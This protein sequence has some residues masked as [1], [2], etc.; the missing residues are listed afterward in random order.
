[1]IEL[2]SILND[3]EYKY[4]MFLDSVIEYSDPEAKVEIRKRPEGFLITIL[5]SNELFKDR[6]IK[7]NLDYNSQMGFKISYSKSLG[8]SRSI[9]Y[10]LRFD[11]TI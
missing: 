9:S 1:M 4:F 8:I 2:P 3:N 6:L 7:N 11:G 10:V 5:P